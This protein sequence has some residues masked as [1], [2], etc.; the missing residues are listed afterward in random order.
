M[1]DIFVGQQDEQAES[2]LVKRDR[3]EL[4]SQ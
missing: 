1:R 4:L 2:S 3:Q